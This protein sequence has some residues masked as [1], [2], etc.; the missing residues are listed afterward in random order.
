MGTRIL[1][2]QLRAG[3]QIPQ[4]PS[5]ASARPGDETIKSGERLHALGLRPQ[6]SVL[7]EEALA[8]ISPGRDGS[9]QQTLDPLPRLVLCSH[10]ELVCHDAPI[11]SSYSNGDSVLPQELDGI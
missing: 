6:G 11:A 4:A 7:V 2:S 1:S 5:F 3:R 8:E 9:W 10:R